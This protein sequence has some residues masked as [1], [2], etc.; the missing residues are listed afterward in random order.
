MIQP[1]GTSSLLCV[2][3]DGVVGA[4]DKLNTYGGYIIADSVGLGDTFEALL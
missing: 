3:R 1:E 4:I 2:P